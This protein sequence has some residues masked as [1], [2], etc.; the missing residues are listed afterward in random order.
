MTQ[1]TDEMKIDLLMK[2]PWTIRSQA[3]DEPGEIILRVDELP[4]LIVI[5]TPEELRGEFWEALRASLQAALHFGDE[6]KLP[7]PFKMPWK[8]NE[9]PQQ[10]TLR[11]TDRNVS[12]IEQL[13]VSYADS[14]GRNELQVV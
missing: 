13:T 11:V 2:M 1:W 3:A 14:A 4:G 5:G 10:P 8:Q 7:V 9:E 12:L 6:I